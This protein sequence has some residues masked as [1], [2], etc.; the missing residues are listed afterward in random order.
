MKSR[1]IRLGRARL[2]A[3]ALLLAGGL[4]AFSA[5][6][7]ADGVPAAAAAQD[8]RPIYSVE[9][10]RKVAALGINCAWDDGDLPQIL[11]TL[12]ARQVKATFFLVG[13]W[14]GRYPGRV[15]QLAAAGHEIGN[16]SDTHADLTRLTAEGI[17]AELEGCSARV[18]RLTGKKPEL[19]R[20]PSGAWNSRVVETARSLGYE[21]IQWDCD[22]LDWQGLSAQEIRARAA[23]GV[24]NGSI[25]LLHSG[26]PHLAEA[27]PGLI[28]DL[29]ERGFS[30]VPVGEMIYRGESR[31]DHA[32]RQHSAAPGR[33]D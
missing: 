31:I 4:L 28:A 23:D 10:G 25:L 20:P 7:A 33:E 30:L 19:F 13:E 26:A 16:H 5:A 27:L 6:R 24:Q 12:D 21:V 29:R 15:R 32:G 14:C 17:A 22:T 9:T 3:A 8:S 1:V 2:A 11:E 18:E